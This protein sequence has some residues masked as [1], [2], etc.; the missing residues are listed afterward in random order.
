MYIYTCT[1]TYVCTYTYT[2]VHLLALLGLGYTGS[3]IATI[4]IGSTISYH[5]NN[6][7]S[8]AVYI[9][10]S[11]TSNPIHVIPPPGGGG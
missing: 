7:H 11:Y 8:L 4:Y 9:E 2:Y 5:S 10:K 3:A 6:V 1:Y